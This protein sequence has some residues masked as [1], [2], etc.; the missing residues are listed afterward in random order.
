[1]SHPALYP[2]SYFHNPQ[3]FLPRRSGEATIK[4]KKHNAFAHLFA[5]SPAEVR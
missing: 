3:I 4:T 1:M 2:V 5:Q